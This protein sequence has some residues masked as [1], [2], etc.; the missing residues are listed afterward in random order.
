[1]IRI[2][3][4]TPKPGALVDPPVPDPRGWWTCAYR[5]P[6]GTG[7]GCASGPTAKYALESAVETVEG[8]G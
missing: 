2:G 3:R 8:R 7:G 5:M 6:S 4:V 1:M